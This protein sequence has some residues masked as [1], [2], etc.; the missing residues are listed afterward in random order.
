[1]K[2][3]LRLLR[4]ICLRGSWKEERLARTVAAM[5]IY[6]EYPQHIQGSLYWLWWQ[7]DYAGL[8]QKCRIQL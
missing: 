3:L 7:I 5:H 8:K 2:K 4:I 6:G 1:M